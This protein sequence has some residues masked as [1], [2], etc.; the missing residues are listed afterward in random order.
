MQRLFHCPSCSR[1]VKADEAGCPFCGKSL[2]GRAPS[3]VRAGGLVAVPLALAACQ[4]APGIPD[5]SQLV[6]SPSVVASGTPSPTPTPG[7]SASPSQAAS[8][9]P[10]PIMQQPNPWA[11][12]PAPTYGKTTIVSGAVYDENGV[13]VDGSTVTVRSLDTSVPY[14]ATALTSQGSW[15]VNSLPEGADVEIVASKPGWTSRRRVGTYQTNANVKNTVNFGGPADPADPI[16]AAYFI[17]DYPEVVSVDPGDDASGADEGSVRYRLT[18]SEPLDKANQARFADALRLFPA[19]RSAA[20]ENDGS[21]GGAGFAD[22]QGQSVSTTTTTPQLDRAVDPDPGQGYAPVAPPNHPVAG[23]Q[24]QASTRLPWDYSIK[25][26]TSFLG[27]ATVHASVTWDATGTIAELDFPAPL[28]ADHLAQARYQVGLVAPGERIVDAHGLQ[29]GLDARG[30]QSTYPLAGLL[31]HAAFEQPVLPAELPA[32]ATGAM[33]WIATHQDAARF[34]V[35]AD[36]DPIKLLSAAYAANVGASSRFELTFSKP[37]AGY[38]GRPG[39]HV[40][41]ALR[42]ASVLDA[43]SLVVSDHPG[44]TAGVDLK[45]GQAGLTL[46]PNAGP[47]GTV[48]QAFKLLGGASSAEPY[49]EDIQV[50]ERDAGKAGRYLLAVNPSNPHVLYIYVVGR[51][52]IFDPRVVEL[53][54]RAPG[55]ADEAGNVLQPADADQQ[56]VTTVDF[57]H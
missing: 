42:T 55:M 29:L 7:P 16:G 5:S 39:G 13:G 3:F 22:L 50:A 34:A 21:G 4:P 38:N 24:P 15:V 2:P 11:S 43:L 49:G 8:P 56:V 27:D 20:P 40:A 54:L 53:K 23:V 9:R 18:L 44:G 57:R 35:K 17:S 48:G 12:A 51:S 37:L 33:R 6:G 1:H 28:I 10:T 41:D 46:D 19:N 31:L 14:T 32:G 30:S 36:A 52:N 47:F 26:G 25:N 45:G